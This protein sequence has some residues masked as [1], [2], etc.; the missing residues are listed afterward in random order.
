MTSW[1]VFAVQI[2][3]SKLTFNKEF[4]K[5]SQWEKMHDKYPFVNYAI[6]AMIIALKE[7]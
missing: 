7:Q 6:A 2:R 3:T 1:S 4:E 5:Y